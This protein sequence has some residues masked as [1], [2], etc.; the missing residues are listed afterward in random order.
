M[1]TTPDEPMEL[2]PRHDGSSS[3]GELPSS[4]GTLASES[5]ASSSGAAHLP[6]TQRRRRG[7][8]GDWQI[9]VVGL[10]LILVLTAVLWLRHDSHKARGPIV[11][12]STLLS[13]NRDTSA[14]A[15]QFAQNLVANEQAYEAA[16]GSP[17]AALY[18]DPPN[19]AFS[20]L[21]GTPCSGG[22]CVLGSPQ[23]LVHVARAHGYADATAFSPRAP[24]GT[25]ICF[26]YSAGG[27][28]IIRCTWIDQVSQGRIDF[29]DGFASSLADAAAMTR[30]VRDA[31]ER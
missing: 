10:A 7:W 19:G 27:A 1:P 29:Y 9:A 13:L 31:I 22:S 17:T 16:I 25:L 15:K 20:V 23:Q 18:G 4:D 3:C 5:P 11:L 12:P 2:L 26:S 21:V 30:Q 8:R 6:P 28:K 24:G 14:P